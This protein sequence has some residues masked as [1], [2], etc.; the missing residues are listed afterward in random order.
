MVSLVDLVTIGIPL[1]ALTVSLL[2]AYSSSRHRAVDLAIKYSTYFEKTT[3]GNPLTS[4]DQVLEHEAKLASSFYKW[5]SFAYLTDR[6]RS[7]LNYVSFLVLICSWIGTNI[8]I[9]IVNYQNTGNINLLVPIG[10]VLSITAIALFAYSRYEAYLFSTFLSLYKTNQ[11]QTSSSAVFFAKERVVNESLFPIVISVAL[12]AVMKHFL[13]F[14]TVVL[15]WG[16]V[17]TVLTI[18][19][20]IEPLEK[21]MHPRSDQQE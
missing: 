21:K 3:P 5:K 15:F 11:Y 6:K 14:E 19:N 9:C 12:S 1:L 8:E 2:T 10:F 17:L 7:Y 20:I 4:F 16:V 18:G 13:D